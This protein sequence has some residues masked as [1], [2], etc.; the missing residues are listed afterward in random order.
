MIKKIILEQPLSVYPFRIEDDLTAL[1]MSF[2]IHPSY[3]GWLYINVYHE[4]EGLIGQVVFGYNWLHAFG[5]SDTFTTMNGKKHKVHSGNFHLVALS[6]AQSQEGVP[7]ELTMTLLKDDDALRVLNDM[8]EDMKQTVSWAEHTKRVKTRASRYYRGD[9]HGHTRYS[10][11]ERSIGEAIKTIESVELDFMAFT[12]HNIVPFGYKETNFLLV[13]SY[14]LTLPN[15]HVNL[16]GVL[17]VDLFKDIQVLNEDGLIELIKRHKDIGHVAINHPF[18]APWEFLY[19]N[20]P[21]RLVSSIEVICDPT[22]PTAMESNSKALRFLDFLWLNG[23]TVNGIGGSDSH[24]KT[25]KFYDGSTLPSVYG[26]PSTYVK[27]TELSANG[28]LNG[29][30]SKDIYVTRFID[31]DFDVVIGSKSVHPG[32]VLDVIEDFQITLCVNSKSSVLFDQT[33]VVVI[34][35]NGVPITQTEI[36]AGLNG[37][38][39]GL[40]KDQL[41][42]LKSDSGAVVIRVAIETSQGEIVGTLNPIGMCL[43][44]PFDGVTF[45]DLKEAFEAND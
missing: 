23:W 26:D 15:G 5:I 40:S 12:E 21:M 24:H 31:I 10:D 20:L 6:S 13:P 36:I 7:V 45:G 27:C 17:E 3:S 33:L 41:E 38:T 44:T 11:G 9:L 4:E 14:E 25:E 1:Y 8:P 42:D 32:V 19:L 28:L 43:P 30:K 29:L 37:I 18:M 16:H 35:I 34:Y 39:H 22:Y 2:E